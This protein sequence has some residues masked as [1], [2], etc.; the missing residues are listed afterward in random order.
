MCVQSDNSHSRSELKKRKYLI[1]TSKTVGHSAGGYTR[2]MKGERRES[3][4]QHAARKEIPD[5]KLNST[6]GEGFNLLTS[7]LAHLD[8]SGL[9]TFKLSMVTLYNISNISECNSKYHYHSSI[10]I[11]VRVGLGFEFVGLGLGLGLT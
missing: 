6:S 4:S 8:K 11:G 2:K 3:V 7:C 10:S 9:E 1:Q 5:S